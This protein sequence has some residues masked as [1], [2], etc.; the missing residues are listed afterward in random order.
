MGTVA[1]ALTQ[2][3][4][5]VAAVERFRRLLRGVGRLSPGFDGGGDRREREADWVAGGLAAQG[6]GG[7]GEGE[8]SE[9]PDVWPEGRSLGRRAIM[10]TLVQRVNG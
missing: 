9:M 5:R 7:C 8:G 1:A 2:G 4:Q 10:M 6:G 3:G